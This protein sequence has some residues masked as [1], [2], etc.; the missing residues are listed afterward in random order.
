[1][2]ISFHV[3]LNDCIFSI[4]EME[5]VR[6]STVNRS[7]MLLWLLMPVV[8]PTFSTFHPSIVATQRVKPTATFTSTSTETSTVTPTDSL[9]VFETPFTSTPDPQKIYIS[10]PLE[11]SVVY[12]EV[13]LL[14]KTAVTGFSR[15]EVEF[16]Y[17][18]NPTDTWF[19]VT[20]NEQPVTEGVLAVWDTSGLTDGDYELRVRVYFMDGS[21]RDAFV[22]GI[23]V[24]NY[25]ATHTPV[26]TSTVKSLPTNIPTITLTNIPSPYP[27]PSPFPS[28]SA[29]VS[30]LQIWYNLG[31]GAAVSI[32]FFA[33]FGW[34]IRL[35][36][37]KP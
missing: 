8:L 21:T 36:N 30:T 12:G 28:N 29:S 1:M 23:R 20:R 7:V 17:N 34:L 19:L 9:N 16:A 35:R 3:R 33:V 6:Q 15:Y 13:N 14:G 5:I 24:R 4:F 32:I 27:A 26:P 31:R 11:G 2:K 22:K 10:E 37:K 25:T 18:A